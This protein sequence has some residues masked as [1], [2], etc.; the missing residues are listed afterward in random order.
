M[1][2]FL[3]KIS[4]GRSIWRTLVFFC[5]THYESL[6]W[7]DMLKVKE[8]YLS[9]RSM[10]VRYGKRNHF[11][12]DTWCRQTPLKN[13]AFLQFAMSRILQYMKLLREDG[14]LI[15]EDNWL[16]TLAPYIQIQLVRMRILLDPIILT[17]G[18]DIPI[19]DW[20]KNGQFSVKSVYKD[21]SNYGIGRSFKHL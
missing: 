7:A 15:T 2:Q 3:G 9:G 4:C 11:W 14:S 19:W 12:C 1:I 17:A 18:N 8:I 5:Q 10:R 6:P 20:N 21:M 16:L 13:M